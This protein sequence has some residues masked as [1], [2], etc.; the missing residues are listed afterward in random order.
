MRMG[1]SGWALLALALLSW[2]VWWLTVLSTPPTVPAAQGVFYGSLLV[3]LTSSGALLLAALQR[4]RDR[5]RARSVAFFIP[6]TLTASFLALFALWLQSLRML[7][8]PNALL[9]F[10]LF[11]IFEGAMGLASRRHWAG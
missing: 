5:R 2:A 4:P 6:H 3:A 9:L 10:A 1:R 11:V 8:W 7:S